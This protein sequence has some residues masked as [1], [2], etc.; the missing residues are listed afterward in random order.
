MLMK[1]HGIS[2]AAPRRGS[3]NTRQACAWG[4]HKPLRACGDRASP[5]ALV[6]AAVLNAEPLISYSGL[7]RRGPIGPGKFRRRTPPGRG[8]AWFMISPT[9]SIEAEDVAQGIREAA[10]LHRARNPDHR[11]IFVCNTPEEVLLLQKFG[12]AAYFYNK[13]ANSSERI[14]RPLERAAVEFDAIYNAQLVPGSGMS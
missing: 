5:D 3:A 13:T 2:C 6:P 9:W 8:P 12:E 4:I 7:L 11:L 14:F 1:D 10:I